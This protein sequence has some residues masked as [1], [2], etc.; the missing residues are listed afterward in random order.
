QLPYIANGMT[1]TDSINWI[2]TYDMNFVTHLDGL[3]MIFGLLVTG[4]GTLAVI[5]SIYYL[6]KEQFILQFYI[7]LLLFMVS[8]LCVVFSDNLM[9]LYVCWTLTSSSSF[10]LIAFWF[11]R[12]VSRYGAKKALHITVLGGF[13]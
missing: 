2:P 10:L 12:K 11:Q 5:Y 3:S 6:A 4:I 7:Y 9:V 13:A 1:F 8:M